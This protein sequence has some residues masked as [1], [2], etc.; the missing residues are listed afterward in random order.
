MV[1]HRS[2]TEPRTEVS[3]PDPVQRSL[4][5]LKTG[6]HWLKTLKTRISAW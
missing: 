6:P 2:A 5:V 3:V 1:Q 4:K